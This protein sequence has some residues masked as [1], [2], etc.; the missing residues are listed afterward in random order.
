[1]KKTLSFGLLLLISIYAQAQT[2]TLASNNTKTQKCFW[3]KI[4]YGVS[5]GFQH[6]SPLQGHSILGTAQMEWGKHLQLGL[7]AGW[8]KFSVS[9]IPV[10]LTSTYVFSPQT[11]SL[12]FS[13]DLGLHFNVNKIDRVQLPQWGW[14]SFAEF[15]KASSGLY[16]SLAVGYNLKANGK[17][18]FQLSM[19][20]TF[21]AMTFY[22]LEAK[23]PVDPYNPFYEEAERN[24][25]AYEWGR[26]FFRMGVRF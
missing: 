11:N 13:G 22:Y 7:G 5:I 24:S 23:V 19:G 9:T 6:N 3:Q 2:I 18:S 8:D 26:L 10:F 4:H 14:G 12:F 25:F 1:M 15:E 21:S 16:S 20:Y 17:T